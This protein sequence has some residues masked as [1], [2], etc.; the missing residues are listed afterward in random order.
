[1]EKQPVHTHF[2]T[3]DHYTLVEAESGS[4]NSSTTNNTSELNSPRNENPFSEDDFSEF[5]EAAD[6]NEPDFN[7]GVNNIDKGNTMLLYLVDIETRS[8]A[9]CIYDHASKMFVV[10]GVTNEDVEVYFRYF[11]KHNAPCRQ[12]LS[13]MF[14]GTTSIISMCTHCNLPTTIDLI[15]FSQVESPDFCNILFHFRP[16]EYNSCVKITLENA[17]EIL[18]HAK[19]FWDVNKK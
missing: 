9:Y 1:M 5:S 17:L 12:L 2:T 18:K 4:D 8:R 7:E 11:F 15:S 6:F 10:I 13:S 19:S 14:D 16:E 3:S